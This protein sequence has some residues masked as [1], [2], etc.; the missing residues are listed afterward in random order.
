MKN[1][2]KIKNDLKSTNKKQE[3]KNVKYFYISYSNQNK[4][5]TGI[6]SSLTKNQYLANDFA[7]IITKDNI[8]FPLE[9]FTYNSKQELINEIA[10]ENKDILGFV[11]IDSTLFLNKTLLKKY[12]F[13][14]AGIY[15]KLNAAYLNVVKLTA[16]L[17]HFNDNN[18]KKVA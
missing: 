15:T 17:K 5:L 3:L 16:L 13:D 12:N 18:L 7:N 2:K 4:N 14:S 1:F 8:K 11:K 10:K 9:S 6:N